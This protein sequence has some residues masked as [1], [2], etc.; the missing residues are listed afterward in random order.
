MSKLKSYINKG[1]GLFLPSHNPDFIII[2][3][4]KSGTTSLHH[5]LK[6]HPNLTG[7]AIKELHYFDQKIWQ[8]YSL[9]WYRGNFV[10]T[11]IKPQLFFESSPSYIYHEHIPGEMA[12]S[13]AGVKL[14]L[15]VRD[16]VK[17]AFSAWNM[18]REV[19]ERKKFKRFKKPLRPGE[20]NPIYKNFF[21]GRET[22]PSFQEAIQIELELIKNGSSVEP[23]LL[24]RGLY[25]QQLKKYYE[26]FDKKD[27]LILGFNDLITNLNPTLIKVTEFLGVEKISFPEITKSHKNSRTYSHKMNPNDEQFLNNF[28]KKPNE[29]LF[30]LIGFRP[31]W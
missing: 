24:R 29:E 1:L 22:F 2:G 9:D 30:E 14:I 16:P 17:R 4:Q 6:Q 21:L 26:H 19:F 15:I 25:A 23:S 7:S 28:F 13:I 10:R 8:G 3:A 20:V 18:Y 5:Y 11:A 27:I 31:N 12:K